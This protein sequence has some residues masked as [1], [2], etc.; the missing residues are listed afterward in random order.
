MILF[1]IERFDKITFAKNYGENQHF[2]GSSDIWN[3]I[4]PAKAQRK[5]TGHG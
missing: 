4:T 2:S 3:D 1:K 5:I